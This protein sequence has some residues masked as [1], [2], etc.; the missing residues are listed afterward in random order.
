V[1]W[2][3]AKSATADNVTPRGGSSL[4]GPVG[5]NLT[6]WREDETFTLG[7]TKLRSE[8][9]EPMRFEFERIPLVL[10]SGA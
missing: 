10:P 9:F 6:V 1:L 4:I 5:A 7:Y 2:H 3:P 8:H